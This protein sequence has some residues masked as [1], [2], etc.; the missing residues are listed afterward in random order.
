[1]K[2]HHTKPVEWAIPCGIF[3]FV[4]MILFNIRPIQDPDIWWH[5]ASGR[6]MVQNMT[7]P[8]HDVFSL[9]AKGSSWI[10]TYWLQEVFTYLLYCIGGINGLIIA[11]S[12]FVAVLVFAIGS[13]NPTVKLPWGTRLLGIFCIYL[14][15]HPRSYGWGERASL[16]TFGFL[17]LLFYT[18]Q[19]ER[20]PKRSRLLRYWPFLFALWA[21]MHRGFI[22]GLVI[23][24]IYVAEL[25]INRN[26]ECRRI[27]WWF[28]LCSV[29]TLINPWGWGFY[30][31]GWHDFRMSPTLSMG[32]AWTPFLHLEI[33]W[34]MLIG[35]W[36]TV[37]WLLWKREPVGFG[38]LSTS[39]LLSWIAARYASFYPYFL[40]WAIPWLLSCWYQNVLLTDNKKTMM[41]VVLLAIAGFVD[42]RLGWGVNPNIFPV[43]ATEFMKENNLRV[44]F[45]HEYT[46]GG[47]FAWEF[48]GNPPVLIDG[49]IP[50]VAGY[51]LLYP[52]LESA[53]TQ[54]P[55]E[56]QNFLNTLGLEAALVNYP[57]TKYL[58]S[59]YAVYF[60]RSQWALIYWDDLSLIFLRREP[61]FETVIRKYEFKYVHPDANPLFWSQKFWPSASPTEKVLWRS[62][63]QE[64]VRRHP[65]S[66]K[67][68]TWAEM[69]R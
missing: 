63:F 52:K 7:I 3:V 14:G 69:A 2:Q 59:P 28:V 57:S 31:M 64:N 32:W 24:G 22:L 33:F 60:P 18:L 19:S 4:W 11:K 40:I 49:R 48:E 12:L 27:G 1:M 47:Y 8:R 54:P 17:G 13:L 29:C 38:F 42:S 10:N 21:N 66:R 6:Y 39:V 53:I 44:P 37:G 26:P 65:E 55:L 43:Q 45:F 51:R 50:A 68:F 67:A 61:K 5:L 36:G 46:W 16:V 15:G 34:F 58:P 9:T 23:L 35:F 20:W 56:F 25:W 30:T 41:V 62:E